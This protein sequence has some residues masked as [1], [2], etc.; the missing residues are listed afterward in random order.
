[1]RILFAAVDAYGRLYPV[2][3]LALAA[4]RMGHSVTLATHPN[5]HSEVERAGL[6]AVAAG[7]HMEDL[8]AEVFEAFAAQDVSPESE[9]DIYV[10][11]AEIA[12][13]PMMAELE[14]V[15]AEGNYDLVVNESIFAAA[16]FAAAKA[17]VPSVQMGVGRIPAGPDWDTIFSAVVRLAADN[18]VLID[19]PMTLDSPYLDLCPPSLQLPGFPKP[20][21]TH[22]L[23]RNTGWN[24][25]GD[26][27]RT[28]LDR[29]PEKPLVYM[30]LG[31]TLLYA[32]PTLFRTMIDAL[33]QLPVQVVVSTGRA[34]AADAFGD[35]PGNVEV[36][37]WVPAT[38]LL[39]V[40]DLA[41]HHAGSGTTFAALA[42][43]VPQLLLPTTSEPLSNA[44][45]VS[46]AGAG[47]LILPGDV[48]PARIADEVRRLLDDSDARAAARKIREEISQL[49]SAEDAIEQVIQA[50]QHQR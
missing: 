33:A 46:R 7:P 25:P 27:P 4:Q 43:G 49:P 10:K 1:M 17:G 40:T 36:V 9:A 23:M 29:D 6:A 41:V 11:A 24:P 45:M 26:L 5:L 50:T 42:R 47:A 31:T 22:I 15:L 30:T 39:D 3:P 18:G 34:V 35:I 8:G 20:G 44:E 32:Q 48:T 21:T 28:V 37:G 19:D 12:T 2:I 16:A 13:G 14:P 38:E